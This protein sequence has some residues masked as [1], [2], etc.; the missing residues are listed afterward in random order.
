MIDDLLKHKAII[1]Q[2]KQNESSDNDSRLRHA[3]NAGR[4]TY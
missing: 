2:M 1:S 4:F 3:Y